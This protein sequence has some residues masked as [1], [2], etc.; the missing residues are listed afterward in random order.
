MK[1]KKIVI[2]IGIVLLTFFLFIFIGTA[3]NR[4]LINTEIE[5]IYNDP[6]IIKLIDDINSSDS[7]E[8]VSLESYAS[9]VDKL[10][11][12][13]PNVLAEIIENSAADP[14]LQQS[15]LCVAQENNTVLP[16]KTLEKLLFDDGVNENVRVE[17][18]SYCSQFDDDYLD[19]IEKLT[20]DKEIAH[21]AIKELYKTNPKKAEA[22]INQTIADYDGRFTSQLQ[23]VLKVWAL[24]LQKKST[25]QERLHFISFCEK[26]ISDTSDDE[27]TKDLLLSYIGEVNSWETFSYLINQTDYKWK[28]LLVSQNMSTIL[29][30]LSG[31]PN[32]EKLDVVYTAILYAPTQTSLLEHIQNN[33]SNNE[34]FYKNNQEL[35]NKAQEAIEEMQAEIEFNNAHAE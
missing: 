30:I 31:E 7:F 23:G 22:I 3:K 12:I 25:E 28:R 11:D 32:V 10:S 19:L 9:L 18:L 35:Y 15:L 34:S 2:I 21:I 26:V 17:V 14:L 24:Q 27:T 6:E 33:L 1:S 29:A 13:S 4:T 8:N 20:N 5:R 16:R